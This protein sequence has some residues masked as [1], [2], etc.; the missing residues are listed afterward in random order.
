LIL[1]RFGNLIFLF[2]SGGWISNYDIRIKDFNQPKEGHSCPLGLNLYAKI[3]ND[4]RGLNHKEGDPQTVS[5][6]GKASYDVVIKSMSQ[7]PLKKLD[8]FV[9]YV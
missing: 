6:R 9:F 2:A 5:V 8:L 3:R 4:F 1:E 7:N